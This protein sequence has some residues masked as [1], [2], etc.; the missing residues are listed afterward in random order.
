LARSADH[1]AA[2]TQIGQAFLGMILLGAV[3]SL[4]ELA[5][6]VTAGV[7]G[8]PSLSTNDVLGSAAANVVVLALADAFVRDRPLSSA[9]TSAALLLQGALGMLLLAVTLGPIVTGDA[10]LLG[11]GRW[12]GSSRRPRPRSRGRRSSAREG[13]STTAR[14]PAA[15]M[16]RARRG[17]R[18]RGSSS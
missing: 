12:S 15:R 17:P 13:A 6:A 9:H 8:T 11:V 10:L 2:R 16:P 3:T 7:S 18:G 14:R 1:I 4:P 5:I